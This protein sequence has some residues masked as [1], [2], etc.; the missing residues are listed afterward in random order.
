MP[1]SKD[2]TK[3]TRRTVHPAPSW[4][5][6]KVFYA[7]V[8]VLT[9][10]AVFQ[11]GQ[12]RNNRNLPLPSAEKQIREAQQVQLRED[13]A[14]ARRALDRAETD[15]FQATEN[16]YMYLE[17]NLQQ[18]KKGPQARPEP[19]TQSPLVEAQAAQTAK[20]ADLMNEAAAPPANNLP[21]ANKP[22]E[23]PK[24]LEL[25]SRIDNLTQ[26]RTELLADRTAEH[27]A[28]RA[29]DVRI[30]DLRRQ[31]ADTNH[32][33]E[34]AATDAAKTSEAATP[35]AATPTVE[36]RKEH[37]EQVVK[38]EA[39]P[40]SSEEFDALQAEVDRAIKA[41]ETATTQERRTLQKC[42]EQPPIEAPAE[43]NVASAARAESPAALIALSIS[44]GF[45]SVLGIGLVLAGAAM[46]PTVRTVS[47]V[48]AIVPA[49]VVGVVPSDRRRCAGM[50]T[51]HRGAVKMLLI[52]CGA[53][54]VLGCMYFAIC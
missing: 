17:K 20:G 2:N 39:V 44:T 36:V 32:W 54:I 6:H 28:I 40:P 43:P 9:C 26:Y 53:L 13:Y 47:E 45:A 23:D 18:T 7:A 34:P 30:A 15:W 8:F 51:R 46:E 19:E 4:K 29:V 12:L 35:T 16:L 22:T 27:P 37:N 52:S 11:W 10:V 5:S 21:V 3:D 1:V 33:I 48:Q 38:D 41:R 42:L 50:A 25:S 49:S 31:L 14:A 24:W